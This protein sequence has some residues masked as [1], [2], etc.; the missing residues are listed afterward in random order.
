[1]K[2]SIS[3]RPAGD[4]VVLLK[5]GR[6]IDISRLSATAALDKLVAAGVTLKDV[7]TTIHYCRV[8]GL[9]R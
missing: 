5:D 4:V 7:A 6:Q 8:H 2:F 1:M 9:P 3:P